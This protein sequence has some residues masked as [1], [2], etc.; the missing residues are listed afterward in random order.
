ME[1]KIGPAIPMYLNPEAQLVEISTQELPIIMTR[2]QFLGTLKSDY[3]R[4]VQRSF[5]IAADV[6]HEKSKRDNDLMEVELQAIIDDSTAGS[7]Q[8]ID[9]R[10]ALENEPMIRQMF[11]IMESGAKDKALAE[12][13]SQTMPTVNSQADYASELQGE[14]SSSPQ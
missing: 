8:A 3:D 2:D 5:W 1:G 4:D 12:S 6:K 10:N 13:L 9:T 7:G 14:T 11:N